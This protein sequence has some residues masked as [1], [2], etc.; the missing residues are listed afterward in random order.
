MAAVLAN[1]GGYYS[2]RV[3]LNEARRLGL[4]IKPPHV[5]HAQHQFRAVLDERSSILY[6]GLD[7]VRELTRQTQRKIIQNRPYS[8]IQDF[9][10]RVNPRQGE[11]DN[12]IKVGAFEG[13]GIIPDLL[14]FVRS[15]GWQV[16]QLTL[17]P[18]DITGDDW[19]LE[20]K[21]NAQEEILGTSLIAHPLELRKE[22]IEEVKAITTLD[23]ISRV[24]EQVTIAGMRQFWR[25][26]T[27]RRGETIYIMTLEDLEGMI[28]VMILP[29]I[30]K[31]HQSEFSG[32]GPYIIEGTIELD[33]ERSEP[34]LI[35]EKIWRIN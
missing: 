12:L 24:G 22:V 30:Y 8:S 3:Y 25:R 33:Q 28:N 15:G 29:M 1:W 31:T 10:S 27:T 32:H 14:R 23:A 19:S 6:M 11:I 16:G 4:I 7:Q 13:L 26:S 20:Q 17:F 34:F 5:N 35:A 9:L 18:V 2:Q 21:V